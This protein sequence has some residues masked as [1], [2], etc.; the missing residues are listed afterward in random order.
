MKAWPA[1]V[2][3]AAG[4]APW[5]PEDMQIFLTIMVFI[6]ALFGADLLF[7][8]GQITQ[9]VLQFVTKMF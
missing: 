1:G 4:V 8:E 6:V 9:Q 3:D 2:W 7:G 5:R